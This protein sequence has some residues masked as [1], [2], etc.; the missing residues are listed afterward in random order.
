M[1]PLHVDL[2]MQDRYLLPHTDVRIELHRNID[3]LLLLCFQQNAAQ[4]K[5]EIREMK[6]FIRK[7][8]VLESIQ[9]A[10]ESTFAN[11]AA[12]YPL[13]RVVV[14]SLHVTQQRRVTPVNSIFQGQIPRRMIIACCDQDAYHGVMNKSPFNFK[15]YKIQSIKVNAGGQSYPA[16]PLKLDFGNDHYLPAYMQLFDALGLA[17]D[18]RGNNITRQAFGKSHCIFAFDLTC[19]ADDGAHWD[20]IKEGNTSVEIQFGGDLPAGGVQV[21]VYAEFDNLLS[22]DRNRIA[23]FDY[24]A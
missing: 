21:I 2:L 17:N 11:Y 15:N 16:Q 22:I 6:L 3:P 8:E 4:Y 20:P 12:K 24:A 10:L 18:N 14:T 5:L 19:D 23:H 7:V 9:L 1:A 13:R